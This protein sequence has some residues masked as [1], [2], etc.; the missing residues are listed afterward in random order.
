LPP[1]G[2]VLED[3]AMVFKPLPAA[4]NQAP[5]GAR[6][7]TE[8][9]AVRVGRSSDIR[10]L[11]VTAVLASVTMPEDFW[12]DPSVPGLSNPIVDHA[13][14]VLTFSLPAPVDASFGGRPG[15]V[16]PPQMVSHHTII[17]DAFT[18]DFIRG[19]LSR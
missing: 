16:P 17:L 8:E 6:V 5:N 10:G 14:W 3:G 9:Q 4:M 7:M 1:D 11:P 18:G 2:L 19:F 15:A 12:D 13:V